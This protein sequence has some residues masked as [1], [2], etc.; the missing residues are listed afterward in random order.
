MVHGKD[1]TN[2]HARGAIVADVVQM[3]DRYNLFGVAAI[4]YEHEYRAV[5]PVGTK[6]PILDTKYG[7]C[8]R[9]CMIRMSNVIGNRW[10]GERVSFVL[11][12]GAASK[13]NALKIFKLSKHGVSGL[14]YPLGDMAFA[15]KKEFGALQ[16]ADPLAHSVHQTYLS[17]LV[18][19]PSATFLQLSNANTPFVVFHNHPTMMMTLKSHVAVVAAEVRR[20]KAWRKRA[21]KASFAGPVPGEQ[22]S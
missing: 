18:P 17:G 11:E 5:F 21:K 16:A 9:Q 15:G 20:E 13:N 3:L 12:D 19:A 10:R 22:S 2:K 4:T 14:V 8:F 1:I 6:V 7:L